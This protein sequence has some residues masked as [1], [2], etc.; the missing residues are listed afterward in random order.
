[1]IKSCGWFCS[2]GNRLLP[3]L[4]SITFIFFH[5]LP[6]MADTQG[7]Y[8]TEDTHSRDDFFFFYT[9]VILAEH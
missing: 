9:Q 5:F 3:S 4:S 8:P 1:M 6:V 7:Q 2:L